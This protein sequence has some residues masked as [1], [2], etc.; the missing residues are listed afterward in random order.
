[1]LN[2]SVDVKGYGTDRYHRIL[3]VVFVNGHNVNIEMIKAG[4]AEVYRG[5]P[6]KNLVLD[7]YW[8]AEMEAKKAKRGMWAL[9]DK[10]IS[11]KEWRK[12]R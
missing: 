5:K 12:M 3:G 9:G 4:L 6:A 1:M 11:P 10:Y 2:N 7:P 8:N